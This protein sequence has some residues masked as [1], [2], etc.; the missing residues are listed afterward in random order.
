MK[1]IEIEKD[2]IPYTF[3]V[4]LTEK[5]YT[6]TLKYN[7]FSGDFVA[8]LELEGKTLVKG[9][10]CLLGEP[11][12]EEFGFDNNSNKN[13]DFYDELLVFYNLTWQDETITLENLQETVFLYVM[14]RD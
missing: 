8:D 11:L 4:V 2:K 13:P 10:K 14:D 1:Y 9:K 6:I 3:D 7:T 12:F 5:T